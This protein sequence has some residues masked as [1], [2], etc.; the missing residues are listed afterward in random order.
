MVGS[1]LPRPKGTQAAILETTYTHLM[2]IN[3]LRIGANRLQSALE[4]LD[5]RVRSL[6]VHGALQAPQAQ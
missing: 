3:S 4:L 1:Q 5:L 6:R 2:D